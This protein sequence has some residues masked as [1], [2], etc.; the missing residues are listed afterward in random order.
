MVVLAYME[1]L[2][3]SA[4]L[5]DAVLNSELGHL[6]VR[7]LRE[8]KAI[9]LRARVAQTMGALIRNAAY[10][11]ADLQQAGALVALAGGVRDRESK[12]RR[13]AMAALG[14]L[15]YYISSQGEPENEDG[16][17]GQWTE[18]DA[19][20]L[21]PSSLAVLT[22]ALAKGEDDIVQHYAAQAL[23]NLSTQLS[24]DSSTRAAARLAP[25][26]SFELVSALWTLMGNTKVEALRGTAASAMSR[27]VRFQPALGAQLLDKVGLPAVIQA[28]AD[29]NARVQ[30]ACINVLNV[31]LMAPSQRLLKALAEDEAKLLTAVLALLDHGTAVVVRAKAVSSVRLLAALSPHWLGMACDKKLLVSVERLQRDKDPYLK[32]SLLGLVQD[33][34]A[35]LPAAV[36]SMARELSV[37][38]AAAAKGKAA[39]PGDV[40]KPLKP[41]LS[42]LPL[43][44]HVVT[45]ISVRAA[46]VGAATVRALAEC[47]TLSEANASP[48]P[49]T[50]AVEFRRVLH[51][52]IEVS[53]P[54]PS[55]SPSRHTPHP[56]PPSL[57]HSLNSCLPGVQALAQQQALVVEEHEA[58]ISHFLPALVQ[59]ALRDDA[60]APP[61]AAA[62]SSPGAAA[63]AGAVLCIYQVLSLSR[64]LARSLSFT[65]IR[66]RTGACMFACVYVCMCMISNGRF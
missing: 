36:A 18:A 19:W 11:P 51:L 28:L 10:I 30:Q 66:T 20:S 3:Q 56:L 7:I 37:H 54:H 26:R 15:L 1:R 16:A 39:A 5:A 42:L 44:L 14:E 12:V 45:S 53:I 27:V 58:V 62:D 17:E 64:S 35:I 61:A 31:V 29:D 52:V 24:A 43:A 48:L 2:A 47:I 9:P 38:R 49:F 13:R 8:T 59:A 23:D 40:L 50:G 65:H 4:A 55:P 57:P 60:A 63:F 46:A 33:V 25:L 22:R 6:M 34:A 21:P 32:R 41:P